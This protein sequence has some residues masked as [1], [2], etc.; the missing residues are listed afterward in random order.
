MKKKILVTVTVLAIIILGITAWF[1]GY[2]NRKNTDNIPSKEIMVT[3]LQEKGE[4]YATEQLIGYSQ[5]SLHYIW[6]EPDIMPSGL[7]GDG[8]NIDDNTAILV[9]YDTDNKVEHVQLSKKEVTPDE[10]NESEQI[11]TTI[12]Y[13]LPTTIDLN[14]ITNCT[15]AVSIE[16]GDIYTDKADTTNLKMKVKIYDYDLFDLVD[17]SMLEVGSILEINKKQ[18]EITSIERNESGTVIINGG[19]DVGGY[20]L[21]TNENGVFYSIGYSDMKT[22][23]EIGEAELELSPEFVYI[24]ASDLDNGEKKYTA[25]NFT[26][27]DIFFDYK[28]TPHNTTIVVEN[29]IVTSMTKIYTP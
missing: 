8:W 18:V 9:F 4:Q 2:H 22:Y 20:D 15:L 13:P 14:N 5:D 6:G 23:Y 11:K 12:V 28:G 19:I 10:T 29:G 25:A 26:A 16:N 24:D 7:W 27:D 1:Y 21:V 17:V 3:Y